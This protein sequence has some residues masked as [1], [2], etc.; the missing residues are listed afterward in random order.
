MSILIKAIALFG[1]NY[2]SILGKMK[3]RLKYN[4]TMAGLCSY[5]DISIR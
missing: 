5:R 1:T 4:K 2:Q 3:D